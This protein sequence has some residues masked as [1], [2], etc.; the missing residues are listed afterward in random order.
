MNNGL[1]QAK[2]EHFYMVLILWERVKYV[3]NCLTE[4]N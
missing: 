2:D 4:I 3:L 1:D